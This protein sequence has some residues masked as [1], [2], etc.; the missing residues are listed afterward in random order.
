M[1]TAPVGRRISVGHALSLV[2]AFLSGA[3][4]AGILS[5]SLPCFLSPVPQSACMRWAGILLAGLLFRRRS[6]RLA[7]QP[8]NNERRRRCKFPAS[9]FLFP[10]STAERTHRQGKKDRLALAVCVLALQARV[11]GG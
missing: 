8:A 9:F 3:G 4:A 6:S 10:P 11:G 1:A 5:L 2:V 7:G